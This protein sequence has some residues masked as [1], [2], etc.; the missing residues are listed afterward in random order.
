MSHDAELRAWILARATGWRSTV[1][2]AVGPRARADRSVDQALNTV[3]AY[4]EIARDLATARRLAP[5]SRTTA[6]LESLYGQLHGLIHRKPRGGLAA[7]KALLQVEIP[8]S[9]REIRGHIAGMACLM[10]AG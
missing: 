2:N 1:Q 3:E 4:R 9:A 7:V 6:A 5:A 8:R 10:I